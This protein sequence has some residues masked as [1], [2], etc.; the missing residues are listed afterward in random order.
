MEQEKKKSYSLQPLTRQI[1]ALFLHLAK[2]FQLSL[3]QV[4]CKICENHLVYHDEQIV[5][6]E[7]KE[8]ITAF[9]AAL[10]K[11]ETC[12]RIIGEG[13]DTC[14]ECLV[15]PPLYRKHVSYSA[16]REELRELLLLYKYKGLEKLKILFAGYY[17]ETFRKEIAEEF[18]FIV[19][20]PPDMSRKREFNPIL[21]IA[22]LLSKALDIK[23]LPNTLVKEKKTLPQAGLSRS[24]RLIN[25]NGAFKI[26]D[27]TQQLKGK[28]LLLL[29]DVYTTGTTIRKCTELLTAEEADVV[30]LTLARSV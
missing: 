11:C 14:G 7:C 20:V 1:P 2:L 26:V 15:T 3:F 8:R 13:L 17:L 24:K 18:D 29:D 9:K 28:K 22:K 19:P 30:V 23:L 27:T 4:R 12:G 16:Y 21:E 25:L 5:C 6:R 10:C